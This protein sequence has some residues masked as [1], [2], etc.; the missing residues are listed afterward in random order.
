MILTKVTPCL[1]Q[2]Q[3]SFRQKPPAF[4][5]GDSLHQWSVL[6]SIRAEYFNPNVKRAIL[7]NLLRSNGWKYYFIL[8]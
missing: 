3:V 4:L 1:T 2:S 6:P 7:Q 5:P 8:E